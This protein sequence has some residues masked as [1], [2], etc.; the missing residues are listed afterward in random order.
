MGP[1]LSSPQEDTLVSC[2]ANPPGLLFSEPQPHT[3]PSL[4]LSEP[5]HFKNKC[6]MWRGGGLPQPPT[7]PIKVPV[8]HKMS[9]KKNEL[10]LRNTKK[11][12]KEHEVT[13]IIWET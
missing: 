6:S 8:S 10:Y 1:V 3:H 13:F 4:E 2:G 5:L 12:I 7:S 11:P 9:Q